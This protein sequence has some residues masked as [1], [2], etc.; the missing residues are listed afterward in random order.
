M[1]VELDHVFVMCAPGAP[2]AAALTR[3]GLKEGPGTHIFEPILKF[4]RTT[5]S[6]K[7]AQSVDH[8]FAK[9]AD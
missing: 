9:S 3:L 7:S 1:S 8:Q 6:V 5:C 2:E 4:S